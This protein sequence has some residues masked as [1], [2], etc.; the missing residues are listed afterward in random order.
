[1]NARQNDSRELWLS[2]I[3]EFFEKNAI[4]SEMPLD[5][6]YITTYNRHTDTGAKQMTKQTAAHI[7]YIVGLCVT[8]W[9]NAHLGSLSPRDDIRSA[10]FRIKRDMKQGSDLQTALGRLASDAYAH[11]D[12]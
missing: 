10:F 9:P 8:Y 12:M 1:M 2:Q 6:P 5:V 3:A 11:M 7:R 4:L